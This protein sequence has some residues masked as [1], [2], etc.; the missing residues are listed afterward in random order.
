MT[1]LQIGIAFAVFWIAVN[2]LFVWLMWKRGVNR[3]RARARQYHGI[4]FGHI[5]GP[6]FVRCMTCGVVDAPHECFHVQP[7]KPWPR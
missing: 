6:R 4:E 1:P 3:E 7:T 5:D 2:V